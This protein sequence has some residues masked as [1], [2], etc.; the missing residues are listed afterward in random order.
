MILMENIQTPL[1]LHKHLNLE[2]FI[3]SAIALNKSPP[4]MCL[5]CLIFICVLIRRDNEGSATVSEHTLPEG[6]SRS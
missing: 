1:F 5:L 3:D 6:L 2:F 4:S